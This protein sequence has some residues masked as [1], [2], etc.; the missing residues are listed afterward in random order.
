MDNGPGAALSG[1]GNV[2]GD[3]MQNALQQQKQALTAREIAGQGQLGSL[4][5]HPGAI[6]NP[7]AAAAI[8]NGVSPE[9]LGQVFRLTNNLNGGVDSDLAARAATGIGAYNNTPLSQQRAEQAHMAETSQAANIA[10]ASQLRT[11]GLEPVQ[12][13]N[14]DGSTGWT[15]KAAIATGAA[16]KGAQPLISP[17]MV[18]GAIESHN[19]LPQPGA[20]PGAPAPD[21][22]GMTD[23]QRS[24]VFGQDAQ[25]KFQVI[26]ENA[27]GAKIYGYP[28]AP[29][30]AGAAPAAP[31][32]VATPEQQVQAMNLHGN[33]FLNT[34]DPQM[35][36]QVQSIIEG[37]TPYPTGML[38]KMPYGQQLAAYVTQADPSFESGNATARV[39]ARQ[40]FETGGPNSVAGTILAG[41]TALAHLGSLSDQVAGLG[42]SNAPFGA[43][44]LNGVQNAVK[45]TGAAGEP[46]AKFNA[47]NGRLAEEMTKFYRGTGGTESDVARDLA[48]IS[49]NMSPTQLNAGLAAMAKLTQGKLD[50]LQARWKTAMGPMVPDF[51]IST[52]EAQNAMKTVMSRAGGAQG[53]LA[54]PPAIPTLP[55]VVGAPSQ[56]TGAFE[57]MPKVGQVIPGKGGKSYVFKGVPPGG[58]DWHNPDY[59]SLVPGQ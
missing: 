45:G 55:S 30:V 16:P 21:G 2:F 10:A 5:A 24:L 46:L 29:P 1:I 27:Y 6:D 18:K 44:L 28:P 8:A 9:T 14:P 53:G 38:L 22:S 41:N 4:F 59:F 42:N 36:G 37:R 47:I 31:S 33:D 52:P 48:N 43:T 35:R 26:G 56:H 7:T 54:S 34:L 19:L 17:D 25:P 50:A 57:D 51:N 23:D 3:P 58:G 20:A 39:K 40:D 11:A 49:P 32:A 15:T 12:I 13:T